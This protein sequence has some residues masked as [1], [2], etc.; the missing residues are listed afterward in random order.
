MFHKKRNQTGAFNAFFSSLARLKFDLWKFSTSFRKYIFHQF[1]LLFIQYIY[2]YIFSDRRQR[3]NTHKHT[4][5]LILCALTAHCLY[6]HIKWRTNKSFRSKTAGGVFRAASLL[7]LGCGAQ[8]THAGLYR[9]ERVSSKVWLSQV[10]IW[11]NQTIRTDASDFNFRLY[12]SQRQEEFGVTKKETN[13]QNKTRDAPQMVKLHSCFSVMIMFKF[14][15]SWKRRPCMIQI[16]VSQFIP[17]MT[18]WHLNRI[19]SKFFSPLS[20]C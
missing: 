12:L 2:T 19:G 5:W 11:R 7:A 3:G 6:F 10:T 14:R 9:S 8:V 20:Y 13:K 1:P 15:L 17:H 16:N 18:Q 4:N